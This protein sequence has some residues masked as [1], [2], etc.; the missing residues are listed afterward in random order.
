V[1]SVCHTLDEASVHAD[2]SQL[3]AKYLID[4]NLPRYFSAWSSD[5]FVFVRDIDAAWKDT[6][7]WQYAMTEALTIVTKDADFSDRSLLSDTGPRVIHLRLSNMR[8][9]EFHVVVSGQWS[10]ICR[11]SDQ[12]QL[13]QVYLDRIECIG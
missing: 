3:M 10:E 12:Y 9:R 7:I 5:D 2:E 4:A 8:M 11:L 1:L 13:V 6:Q